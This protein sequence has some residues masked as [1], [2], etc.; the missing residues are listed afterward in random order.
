MRSKSEV[1]IAN[2]LAAEEVPFVYEQPLYAPD[3]TMF[4]PDFT[5]KFMGETYYWETCGKIRLSR[6]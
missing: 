1:I 6:L 4:L 2:M 5:V 3:G